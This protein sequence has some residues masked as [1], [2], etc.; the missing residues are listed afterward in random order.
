MSRII[1]EHVEP[2][3]DL[4]D[5]AERITTMATQ[6]AIERVVERNAPEVH[7]AFDGL[8]CVEEDC[9]VEIPAERL[10]WGRVRCTDCQDR[11]EILSKQFQR[12]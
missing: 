12:G 5:H 6:R 8:H 3:A 4:L 9:G 2:S 11:R 10:A 1:P 7:H